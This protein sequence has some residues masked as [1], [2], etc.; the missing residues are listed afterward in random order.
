[1]AQVETPEQLAAIVPDPSPRAAAKVLDRLDEQALEFVRR[2]PFLFIGT[3]GE[4]GI[5]I[6]PKGDRAGFV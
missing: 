4:A 5:E 6:S 3:E 2:S 1:M